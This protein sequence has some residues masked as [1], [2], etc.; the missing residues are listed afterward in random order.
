MDINNA[1]FMIVEI[2][3][4]GGIEI[5]VTANVVQRVVK[6]FACAVCLVE[7]DP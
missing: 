6:I 5:F 3:E 7:D 4:L 2:A 1:N